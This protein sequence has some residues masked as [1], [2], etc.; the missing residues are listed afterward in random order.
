[1]PYIEVDTHEVIEALNKY[2]GYVALICTE[3]PDKISNEIYYEVKQ[4]VVTTFKQHTG[5]LLASVERTQLNPTA[6]MVS[7]AD[8]R[9]PYGCLPADQEIPTMKGIK[10]AKDI[11]SG[12]ILFSNPFGKVTHVYHYKYSGPLYG[13]KRSLSNWTTW[14]TPE[15]RILIVRGKQCP[16]ETSYYYFCRPNC[17]FLNTTRDLSQCPK[18]WLDYTPEFIPIKEVNPNDFIVKPRIKRISFPIRELFDH[19]NLPLEPMLFRLIGYYI[20]EGHFYP[21]YQ[22]VYFSINEEEI[23]FKNHIK[24]LMENYFN[25]HMFIRGYERSRGIMLGFTNLRNKYKF[26]EMFGKGA[27][28]KQLPYWVYALDE[29]SIRQLIIGWYIG[30]GWEN[31]HKENYIGTSSAKLAMQ[32]I[33]LFERLGYPPITYVIDK[34]GELANNYNDLEIYYRHLAFRIGLGHQNWLAFIEGRKPYKLR[35]T[36]VLDDYI[37]YRIKEIKM[38]EYSGDIYD[39]TVEPNHYFS[40]FDSV[41]SNSYQEYGFIHWRSH[42]LVRHP[43]FFPAVQDIAQKYDLEVDTT[44]TSRYM[45]PTNIQSYKIR[46]EFTSLGFNI[47]PYRE[48]MGRY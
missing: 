48:F 19:F 20:A 14:F 15:H 26:F 8:D 40:S 41:M 18:Y 34:R 17:K 30:D 6:W 5:N 37:L 13:I 16:L 7:A 43:F 46:S 21:P 29:E 39:Y 33:S 24:E 42:R 31:G 22:Q 2:I 11:I 36:I 1:M 38:K 28:N 35:D 25:A 47:M 9:A 27:A 45:T 12:D 3:M 32:L 4:N 23:E 10:K 44:I